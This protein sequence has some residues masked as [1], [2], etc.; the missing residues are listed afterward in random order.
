MKGLVSLLVFPAFELLA[1]S[2]QGQDIGTSV[3]YNRILIENPALAGTHE[4]GVLTISYQD[5]Y[6]GNN[7]GLGSYYMSY[8]SWFGSLHGGMGVYLAENRMGEL[9]ND[10]R[11]GV[12]WAYHL[13]ATRELYINAGFLASVI[14][15]SIN[16]GKII[17][18]EQIDPF[19]GPVLP[20]S[21]FTGAD[22][23]T[24]FDAGVGFLFSYR[25]SHAGFSVNHLATP[26]ISGSGRR[27]GKIGRRI[28][29]HGSTTL[30][31]TPDLSVS[32]L[33]SGT[34]QDNSLMISCGSSVNYKLLA[35]NS[36]LYYS[37]GSGLGAIQAGIFIETGPFALSYSYL[38]NISSGSVMIPGTLSNRIT[39]YFSLNNVDKTDIINTINCPKL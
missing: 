18:P 26:D 11:S 29:V 4:N 13:R 12:A 37:S 5:F 33:M 31:I 24:L 10:L 19:L 16:T 8:D 7:F 36:L 28:T 35:V 6:P 14:H 39:L 22:Q 3:V 23:R 27:E 38:F 15:R 30:E 17:L 1:F 9:M 25:D 32:P 2:L 34:F 21:G 20:G